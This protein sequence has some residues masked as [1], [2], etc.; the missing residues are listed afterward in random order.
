MSNRTKL[1]EQKW[2]YLLEPWC[3]KNFAVEVPAAFPGIGLAADDPEAAEA[4]A[5]GLL[6]G[7]DC[8]FGLSATEVIF[9]L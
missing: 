2:T 7:L 8:G 3:G 5:V 1:F 9:Y 6:E 4:P